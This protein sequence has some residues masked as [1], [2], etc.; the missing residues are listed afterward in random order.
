MRGWALGLA[1]LVGGCA[2]SGDPRDPLEGLNRGVL[3]FNDAVDENL[4]Q[5]AARL[6]RNVTPSGLRDS[7]R[8][9]FGNLDDLYIGANNLLQGKVQEGLGDLMRVAI[10]TTFGFF[11]IIDWASDMGLEKHNEDFGQ[12][13]ASWGVGDGAYLVLPLL[14]PS[15][16]RDTAALPV[17]WEGDPVLRHTPVDER[18][19]LTATRTVARRADLL[20]ASSTLEEAAL[21]RYVFLREAF[22]QRRRSLVY[23]GRPPR[24]RPP[25][26]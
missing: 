7:V 6:Y 13:L 21:D 26:D 1:L 23:D 10:N 25:A 18:N 17:D 2:T 22:L 8:N 9:F 4:L 5:P 20:G 16:L 15:T 3:V 14:G 19:A 24:E 11:G 12:T